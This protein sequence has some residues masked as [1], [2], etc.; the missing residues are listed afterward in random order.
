MYYIAVFK[1]GE[2]SSPY[3]NEAKLLRSYDW[4]LLPKSLFKIVSAG[5]KEKLNL[6][7]KQAIRELK[8]K[9][10]EQR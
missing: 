3:S 4:K 5:T 8:E 10:N 1:D 9:N 2:V 6:E 7:V